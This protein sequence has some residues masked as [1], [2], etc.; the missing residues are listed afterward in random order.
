[1]LWFRNDLRV[2]DNVII[3]MAVQRIK[4]E[5]YDEVGADKLFAHGAAVVWLQLH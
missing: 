5:E 4:A 2:R 1:M 3:H